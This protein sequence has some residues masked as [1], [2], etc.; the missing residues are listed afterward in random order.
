MSDLGG[1]AATREM[2]CE[3]LH[4][5][6]RAMLS[7]GTANGDRHIA[8]LFSLKMGEPPFEKATYVFEHVSYLFMLF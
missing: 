3:F 7:T 2:I 8:A 6:D 5:I 4:H 1:D